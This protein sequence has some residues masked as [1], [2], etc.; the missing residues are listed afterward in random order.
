MVICGMLKKLQVEFAVTGNGLEAVDL[1]TTEH[2][3]F[4]LILMDCEMPVMDGY[5]A[6]RRI[7]K[8]EAEQ[9]LPAIPILALTAHALEEHS[10]QAIRSGMNHHI[11]KP[12]NF[13]TLQDTLITYLL[14]QAPDQA[15]G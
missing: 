12:V 4:D 6:S 8:L 5:E 1:Y 10:Q 7:R 3:Q 9:N 13:E 2:D 11:A 15:R 14:P